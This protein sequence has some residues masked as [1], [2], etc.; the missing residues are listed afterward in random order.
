MILGFL[1]TAEI[2]LLKAYGQTISRSLWWLSAVLTVLGAISVY[3]TEKFNRVE[4]EKAKRKAEEA[5]IKGQRKSPEVFRFSVRRYY[6][7]EN[8]TVVCKD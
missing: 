1:C 6:V 4:A 7:S 3:L 5:L 2:F 8:K